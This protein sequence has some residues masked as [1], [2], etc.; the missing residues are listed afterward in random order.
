MDEENKDYRSVLL[1]NRGTGYYKVRYYLPRTSFARA[2]LDLV[3]HLDSY[4]ALT[5]S[6][7]L[8]VEILRPSYSRLY[9]LANSLPNV[10]QGSPNEGKGVP[11]AGELGRSGEGL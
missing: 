9:T 5:P 8:T 10:L 6:P 3:P 7:A 11:S 1:S 4:L 2:A